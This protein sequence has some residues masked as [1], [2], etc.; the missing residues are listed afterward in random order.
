[1]KIIKWFFNSKLSFKIIMYYLAIF[2][3]L[4]ILCLLTFDRLNNG[5]TTQKVNQLSTET[6]SSLNSNLDFLI[7]TVNN[8]SKMLISSTTLQSVLH[9]S[10][11]SFDSSDQKQMDN[12]LSEFTNFYDA[13]SS[14]YVFDNSGHE[15]F[16]DNL[17]YKDISLGEIKAASWYNE[18]ISKSGGYILKLNVGGIYQV[19]SGGKNFI[20]LIRVIN[21]INTQ[22]PMGIMIVNISEDYLS[23]SFG[24]VTST[25]NTKIMLNDEY[26][27]QIIHGNAIDNND[28][29]KI[30][31]SIGSKGISQIKSFD[32]TQYIIS[33]LKNKY[34]WTIA[35]V[36]PI[37]ELASQSQTYNIFMVLIVVINIAMLVA[38]L[39]FTSLFITRPIKK[40]AQAMS[41]VKTGS[42]NEVYVHTGADEIGMLKDV[43]NLMIRE[44]RKLFE[45]IVTEQHETQGGT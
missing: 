10:N 34:N 37:N 29:A 41:S 21:D 4:A 23:S 18:L 14:I 13:I 3:L 40:L 42:F 26:N 33:C 30:S 8:Q 28:L 20:S 22:K 6:L 31:K 36:T 35:T 15:Y 9:D 25:T 24:S 2:I 16:V 27:S 7:S 12:Y 11:Q 45:N 17:Y 5:L 38:A 1:M 43:Y 39:I 44:I 32:G 19:K